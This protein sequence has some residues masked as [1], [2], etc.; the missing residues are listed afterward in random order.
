MRLKFSIQGDDVEKLMN[1]II[2]SPM[3]AGRLPTKIK[4]DNEPY[5]VEEEWIHN[6]LKKHKITV[7][8]DW[9]SRWHY[10]SY[11]GDNVIKVSI[12]EFPNSAR[13]VL[14][15]LAPLSWTLITF[16]DLHN[17]WY[18][19]ENTYIGY[20]IAYG[21]FQLGWGCAFKG[22]GHDRLV[23]RRWLYQG[24]WLYL[25]GEHD[26]TLIQ[27]YDLNA[28]SATAR[29][30]AE[31]A[32]PRM[33]SRNIGGYIVADYKYEYELKGTY[34]PSQR[35]HRITVV[36]REVTQREMLDARASVIRKQA[37]PDMPLDNVIF[38]FM[39]KNGEMEARKYLH[40]LWLRGLECWTFI[41]DSPA[42]LDLD[43]QHVPVKPEWVQRVLAEENN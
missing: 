11:S 35:K 22:K 25:C 37:D 17:D 1:E 23:T 30:Q 6:T 8:A 4:V 42:Q 18:G 40:E 5:A 31:V 21:H 3:F 32:H 10:I 36:E 26:T 9:G 2:D 15:L 43:Y 20:S 12:P 41:D 19:Q 13:T 24:P 39:G 16:D 29:K 28:D 38:N 7:D 14:E 27:F 34:A 33:G